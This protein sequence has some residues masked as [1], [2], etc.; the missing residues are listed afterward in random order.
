MLLVRLCLSSGALEA[1]APLQS[2]YEKAS[3]AFKEA[4]ASVL[5]VVA[6][7]LGARARP[8][9]ELM[10]LMCKVKNLFTPAFVMRIL[11]FPPSLSSLYFALL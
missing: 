2:H 7:V 1:V 6:A 8:P 10:E 9:Q 3:L 5:M 11:V 4:A